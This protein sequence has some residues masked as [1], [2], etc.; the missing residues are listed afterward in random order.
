MA[1]LTRD[2]LGFLLAKAEQ[3]WN[4]LLYRGFCRANYHE[5]RP[6][7]GSVLVPLFEE[8]GLRIGELAKRS[9]M[10]KQTMTTLIRHMGRK[11]LVVRKQDAVDGRAS[12]V[13]L[14]VRTRRFR[15]IAE[16]V[17]RRLDNCVATALG[18]AQ[19]NELKHL[20][21]K[22]QEVSYES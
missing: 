20:L 15:A 10:S 1:T 2:N 17:L 7:Y 19:T 14:T 4:E 18:A 8:D 22:I 13:Y 3:R 5:I 21:K 16:K 9:R 6:A 12:R 11:K